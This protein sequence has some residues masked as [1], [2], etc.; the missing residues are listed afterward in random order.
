MKNYL[1]NNMANERLPDLV[2]KKRLVK[3]LDTEAV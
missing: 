2:V 3:Q 1:R